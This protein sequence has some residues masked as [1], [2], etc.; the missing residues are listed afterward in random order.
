MTLSSCATQGQRGGKSSSFLRGKPYPLNERE[1]REMSSPL[2]TLMGVLARDDGGEGHTWYSVV[3]GASEDPPE[4]GM[5]PVTIESRQ[6]D[7]QP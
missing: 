3:L 2:A 4:Q 5:P 7:G 1:K 6:Q